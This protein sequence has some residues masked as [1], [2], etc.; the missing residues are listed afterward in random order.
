[1]CYNF[2]SGFCK[3]DN[4]NDVFLLIEAHESSSKGGR[5][6]GEAKYAIYPRTNAPKVNLAAE[7][8]EDMYRASDYITML[9]TLSTE[10]LQM[11]CGRL[12]FTAS[13]RKIKR[14]AC[15]SQND[16]LVPIS[17][18]RPPAE[19]GGVP[20]PSPEPS[21]VD[22]TPRN[23]TP[24]TFP[25]EVPP[26]SPDLEEPEDI[27]VPVSTRTDPQD[28]DPVWGEHSGDKGVVT[29]GPELDAIGT[30]VA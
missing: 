27:V 30:K 28:A 8:D 21:S 4:K 22:P 12:K 6:V 19:L 15:N 18:S 24:P 25:T 9:R 11:H 10:N 7:I 1:V 3:N 17:V 14:L 29:H 16:P 26:S 23:P 13:L 5:R 2:V 20:T